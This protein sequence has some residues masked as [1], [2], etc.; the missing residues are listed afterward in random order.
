CECDPKGAL[1]ASCSK[2]GGQCTCRR[3]VVGRKCD[4][5][6]ASYTGFP[7]CR[8]CECSPVGSVSPDCDVTG[9]CTCTRGF[10]GRKCDRCASYGYYGYPNCKACNCDT[11]GSLSTFCGSWGQCQ[12]RMNFEGLKCD[13]CRV[14][15]YDF[16]RCKQCG[17]NPAGIQSAKIAHCTCKEN[18]QGAECEQCKSMH[19]GLSIFNPKGC[20]PCGC[21]LNGTLGSIGDC[22]KDHGRC[23]CKAHVTGRECGRCADGYYGYQAAD[24]F[25]C[26]RCNCKVGNSFGSY[27]DGFTGQCACMSN[28]GGIHCD[29]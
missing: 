10:G 7:N 16:P 25:G 13:Q 9:H 15:Y 3:N 8:K 29:R 4:R 14:G 19:F 24:T 6:M 2:F 18:V 26:K 17:C 28:V 12:C 22:D 21:N 1:D 27:C 5:C 23:N 20:R 11:R